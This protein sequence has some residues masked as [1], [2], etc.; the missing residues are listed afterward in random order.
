M[1]V[2]V[3]WSFPSRLLSLSSLCV[4]GKGPTTHCKEVGVGG[5]ADSDDVINMAFFT[6]SSSIVFFII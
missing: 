1:S 5:G 2:L 3:Y 4:V 6:Y